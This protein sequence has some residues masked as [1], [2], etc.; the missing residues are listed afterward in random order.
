MSTIPIE[1]WIL[2]AVSDDWESLEDIYRMVCLEF[3]AEE[4][5]K[6][7]KKSFYWRRSSNN[8]TLSELAQTI[9]SLHS[10]GQIDARDE[11]GREIA[12]LA[13][14]NI[15]DCWFKINRKGR[16]AKQSYQPDFAK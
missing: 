1:Y 6:S 16:S 10:L 9:F 11:N 2:D 3:S 5:A 8:F 14:N 7:D 12:Q 13:N 4:F 15:F